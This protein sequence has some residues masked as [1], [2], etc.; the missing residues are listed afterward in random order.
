MQLKAIIPARGGSKGV[1]G[2]NIKQI[3]NIP[4]LGYPILAAQQSKLISDIYVSTD[5]DTIAQVAIKYGAKIIERPKHLAEDDSLDI[6][7]MRHAVDQLEDEGDIVHLRATTPMIK[8]HILDEAIKYY[9]SNPDCTSLRS[10]HEA[11]ETAYKS[12]KLVNRYWNGLFDHEYQG[13]YYNWPRQ[14][15]PKTYQANG[16][17]DIIKPKQFMNYNSLHGDKVLAY[18]TPFTHEVDTLNDFNILE[19]VYG[20]HKK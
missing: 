18:T 1:P 8:G 17:I 5:D 12:F 20:T 14:L 9:H 7:V 11:S 16:Y 19:T 10:G 3:N 2:K 6:D 15:L 4:L 13:E